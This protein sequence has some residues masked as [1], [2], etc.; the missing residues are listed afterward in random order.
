MVCHV[1]SSDFSNNIDYHINV[2]LGNLS[3]LA[4][5]FPKIAMKCVDRGR[6]NSEP[7]RLP[8]CQDIRKHSISSIYMLVI[9]SSLLIGLQDHS[10][11]I[12]VI[13]GTHKV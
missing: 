9:I 1:S 11:C 10:A 3:A 13:P 7:R 6:H 4:F 8:I 12:K 2:V 5:I